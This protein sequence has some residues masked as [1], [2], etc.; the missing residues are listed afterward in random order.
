MGKSTGVSLFEE[1]GAEVRPDDPYNISFPCHPA[2]AQESFPVAIEPWVPPAGMESDDTDGVVYYPGYHPLVAPLPPVV[3]EN[4]YKAHGLKV[5]DHVPGHTPKPQ[6]KVTCPECAAIF[7]VRPHVFHDPW[8]T[9]FEWASTGPAGTRVYPVPS[10][11]LLGSDSP[12]WSDLTVIEIPED[13]R[14]FT[15]HPNDGL[16]GPA[17]TQNLDQGYAGVLSSLKGQAKG[18]SALKKR[19]ARLI[20]MAMP[21]TVNGHVAAGT[22][23]I[24]LATSWWQLPYGLAAVNAY[25]P[26]FGRGVVMHHSFAAVPRPLK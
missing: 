21:V 20:A 12:L 15:T 9:V 18:W 13:P 19:P 6:A 1:S 7:W 26:R 24:L 11:L 16:F 22:G 5:H 10:R 8:T 23:E 2:H 14:P 4:Y 3:W 17:T 25:C